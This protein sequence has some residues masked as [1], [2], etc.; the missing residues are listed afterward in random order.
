VLEFIFTNSHPEDVKLTFTVGPLALPSHKDVP[1][2]GN[3]TGE[4][5]DQPAAIFIYFPA[6]AHAH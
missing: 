1:E 5:D 2:G 3:L 4:R 6:T